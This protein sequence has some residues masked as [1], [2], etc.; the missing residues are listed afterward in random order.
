MP[1]MRWKMNDVQYFLLLSLLSPLHRLLIAIV[2][3]ES[4]ETDA[5]YM[6]KSCDKCMRDYCVDC[7]AMDH[8]N[9]CG[10]SCCCVCNTY[11]PCFKCQWNICGDC[12]SK[13][14]GCSNCSI[15]YCENCQDDELFLCNYCRSYVC[16]NCGMF[17]FCQGEDCLKVCCKKCSQGDTMK[18]VKCSECQ[19][20]FCISCLTRRYNNYGTSNCS[21]CT[22][23]VARFAPSYL[24][25]NE[26]LSK[27]NEELR[28]EVTK[29]KDQISGL[30]NTIKDRNGTS[31]WL[32]ALRV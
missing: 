25:E 28:E 19:G 29:L 31:K 13:N 17:D 20:Y 11:T 18:G 12:N 8:C 32:E 4:E 22:R 10:N 3:L 16:G 7:S 21:E 2:Y 9:Y 14:K 30:T 6:L 5:V 27:D 1:W 26:R 24:E 15:S 23:R